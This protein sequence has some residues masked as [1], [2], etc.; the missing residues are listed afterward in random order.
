VVGTKKIKYEKES[1]TLQ[2]SKIEYFIF[3]IHP[4]WLEI[5]HHTEKT[6]HNGGQDI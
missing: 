6:N 4:T 2:I 1:G 3:N 5:V